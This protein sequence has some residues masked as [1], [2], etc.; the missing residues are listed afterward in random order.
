MQ[1]LHARAATNLFPH[2][3]WTKCRRCRRHCHR[4]CRRLSRSLRRRSR[5][6]CVRS[7]ASRAR[8]RQ[9][10]CR[11]QHP[12]LSERVQEFSA[13]D[14]PRLALCSVFFSMK[15]ALCALKTRKFFWPRGADDHSI[16]R[17]R[18][19]DASNSPGTRNR[20]VATRFRYPSG[21]Q[22]KD[23]LGRRGASCASPKS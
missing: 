14:R 3:V 21:F 17:I 6:R 12:P 5:R 4:R 13:F 22:K 19:A 1:P 16:E 10:A 7:A 8:Q 15:R 2:R 11:R 23:D 18:A 9:F 20:G